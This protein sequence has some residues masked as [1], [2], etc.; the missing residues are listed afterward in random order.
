M[1]CKSIDECLKKLLE[2]EG[3]AACSVKGN[4]IVIY[5]EDEKYV[6]RATA[7]ALEGYETEVVN[8]K[9][10]FVALGV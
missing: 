7:F 9:G 8:I 6:P 5:V 4:K 2:Q 3:I 1:S 10:R